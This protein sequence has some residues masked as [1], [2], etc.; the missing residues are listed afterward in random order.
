M[1]EISQEEYDK[2]MNSTQSCTYSVKHKNVQTINRVKKKY[3]ID[4]S[5]AVNKIIEEHKQWVD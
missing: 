3:K 1:V 2:I 4:K 5:K